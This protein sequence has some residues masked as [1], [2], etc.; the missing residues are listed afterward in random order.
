M[1]KIYL[2]AG[3]LLTGSALNAQ[4]Q[5]IKDGGFQGT[6]YSGS[7]VGAASPN[8]GGTAT[9]TSLE[10]Q[11]IMKQETTAPITSTKSGLLV[12]VEDAAAADIIGSTEPKTSGFTQ[13][14][15]KGGALAGKTPANLTFSFK[16]KYAPA[17]V[18]TALVLVNLIDS[19]LTGNAAIVYQGLAIMVGQTATGT[20]KTLTTWGAG[21]AAT[22][23]T[24]NR[25]VITFASSMSNFFDDVPANLG[26]TLT[27]DDVSF[28]VNAPVGINEIT[29]AS[30]VVYPNPVANTL[31]VEITNAEA[32]S[33]SIYSLDGT[34]VRTADLNG[35]KG[36]V[37]VET[38]T[39]GMY[40]YTIS[41]KGGAVI[42]SR[43]LKN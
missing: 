2:I 19:T 37:N 36:S 35:V 12:S 14:T 10:W 5:L 33:I 6:F 38:L 18:D 3:L 32:T 41:T 43:F 1:K 31:N 8:I 16:Y 4:T 13:Q 25:A 20:A 15:Y 23:G 34:L 24:I 40:L 17:G 22:T 9:G 42:Q 11:G 30:S 7:Q 28:T 39:S 29:S 27:V 21:P 26:S